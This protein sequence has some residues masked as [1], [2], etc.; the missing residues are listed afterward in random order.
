ME[1]WRQIDGHPKHEVSDLGNIRNKKTGRIM[2]QFVNSRGY[3]VLMIDGAA[4]RVHRLVAKAFIPTEDYSLD[5]NHIDGNKTNNT[6]KNLEWCTRSDNIRHAFK[7]GLSQSNL[8]DSSRRLGNN[9]MKEKTS[10]AVEV[11]E[12]G[13][14]YPSIKECAK[15]IGGFRVSISNCC[16]G[17]SKT[18]RGLHFRF[19]D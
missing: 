13:V 2:K 18:H 8:N 1:K 5:V 12:T 19:K 17:K 15:E 7:N 10:R 14:T 9:V 6:I 3:K 16:H 11:I 4:E